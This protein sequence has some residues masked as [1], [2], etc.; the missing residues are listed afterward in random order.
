MQIDWAF[1]LQRA[2]EIV[3]SYDT[4]VILPSSSC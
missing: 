3:D 1:V 4:G 2:G